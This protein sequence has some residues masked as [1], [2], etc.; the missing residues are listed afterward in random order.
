M[1]IDQAF[2]N[3]VTQEARD[4][5]AEY[6]NL[7]LSRLPITIRLRGEI[8]YSDGDDPDR[9]A[10]GE[11][12]M[13][14]SPDGNLRFQ[15]EHGGLEWLSQRKAIRETEQ[16]WWSRANAQDAQ[17]ELDTLYRTDLG[18]ITFGRLGVLPGND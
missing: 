6:R 5:L 10:N 16:F 8:G 12:A 13:E 17:E 14:R 11:L 4:H 18:M 1:T 2:L 15:P 9:S 3:G 7:T